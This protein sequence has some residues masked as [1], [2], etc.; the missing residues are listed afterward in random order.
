MEMR[1][2]GFR[3]MK[4]TVYQQSAMCY[5]MRVRE[6]IWSYDTR[7]TRSVHRRVEVIRGAM[8]G[9]QS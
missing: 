2:S 4:R 8:T 6:I 5:A 3:T 1:R 9:G 7:D